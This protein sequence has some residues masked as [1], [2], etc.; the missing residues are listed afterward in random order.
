MSP[1]LPSILTPLENQLGNLLKSIADTLP[2]HS[3]A[4]SIVVLTAIV[5]IIIF[6][7]TAKQ[8]TSM[9]RMQHLQPHIKKLQERYKDD[10]QEMQ[11]R[12]MEFYRDNKVNPL[13]SC[14]PVVIQIPVFLALFGTLRHYHYPANA[15]LS[16]F[17][18]FVPDIK[19]ALDKSGSAGIILIV[20]YVISQ[21]VSSWVMSANSPNQQQRKLFLIM[22]IFFVVFIKGFAIGVM[23]YW[24][25]SNFWTLGQY[26]L[27][28][29][30]SDK[31]GP[32][33]IMPEDA[34]GNKKVIEAAGPAAKGK[35]AK[36]SAANTKTAGSAPVSSEQQARPNKRRR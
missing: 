7:L 35:G 28:M 5:R 2:G 32:E 19:V 36:G 12:L 22:P 10:K 6:P 1:L 17:G 18:S 25:T 13:A 24:I 33:I 31:E 20:V 29:A 15:D 4:W 26:K 9:M 14:F 23:L 8:T 3:W 30:F 11:S 21:M 16:L 27:I 34:K